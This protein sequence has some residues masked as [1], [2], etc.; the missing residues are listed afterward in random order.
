MPTIAVAARAYSVTLPGVPAEVPARSRVSLTRLRFWW[1]RIS[2]WPAELLRLIA[3][4]YMLPIVIYAI[5]TPI[6]VVANAVLFCA[7]WSWKALW[8]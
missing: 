5:G 4:V 6:A 3:L 1:G 7:G 8:Q 2:F